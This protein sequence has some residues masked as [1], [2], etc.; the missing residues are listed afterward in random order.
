MSPIT[1]AQV[2]TLF[3]PHGELRPQP[4]SDWT[5]DAMLPLPATVAAFY[6]EVGPWGKTVHASVGPVGITLF[7]LAV[8]IPPLRRLADA[9]AGHR[10]IGN[11][12]DLRRN[13]AWPDDWLVVASAPDAAFVLD[14]ASQHVL[15]QLHGGPAQVFAPDLPTA[16]AA[17]ATLSSAYLALDIADDG[18]ETDDWVDEAPTELACAK[19]QA[20]LAAWVGKPDAQRMMALLD[21]G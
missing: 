17:L 19:M 16:M 8:N 2:R 6:A 4:A 3:E 18:S 7:G 10:I 11:P 21:L 20:A 9:Q 5:G 13:P 15:H 14:G 1:F 12:P